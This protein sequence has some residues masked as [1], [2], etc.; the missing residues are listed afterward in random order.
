MAKGKTKPRKKAKGIPPE[1]LGWPKVK[2]P[3]CHLTF[4]CD[5]LLHLQFCSG[6]Q[7]RC[8]ACDEQADIQYCEECESNLCMDCYECHGCGEDAK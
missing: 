8:D 1:L 5:P 7:H 2:C 3:A 4:Q 6:R